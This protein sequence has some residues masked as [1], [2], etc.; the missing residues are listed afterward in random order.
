MGEIFTGDPKNDEAM[1]RELLGDDDLVP[2]SDRR[3]REYSPEFIERVFHIP[4]EIQRNGW[5]RRK[6]VNG[7][8]TAEYLPDRGSA[9]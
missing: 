7:K 6:L 2:L 8:W 4:K 9:G 3:L 1:A 5:F